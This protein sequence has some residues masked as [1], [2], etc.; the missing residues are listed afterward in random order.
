MYVCNLGLRNMVEAEICRFEARSV[1]KPEE[2]K[3]GMCSD[4]S[5]IFIYFLNG[6]YELLIITL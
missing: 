6:R 2:M 4:M 1:W 3:T 5:I